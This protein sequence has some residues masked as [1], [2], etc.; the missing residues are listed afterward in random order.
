MF[1]RLGSE[2]LDNYSIYSN[3]H[4]ASD[5]TPLTITILIVKEHIQT[6]KQT[7][8]KDSKEEKIFVNELIKAIRDIDTCDLSNIESLE[9]VVLIL[10]CFM[11]RI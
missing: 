2:E 6:K 3:W 8:V 11:E 4:L 9:N 5:Y 1:L 10:A 7:I